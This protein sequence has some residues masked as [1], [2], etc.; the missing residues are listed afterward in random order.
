MARATSAC[1]KV[2]ARLGI[3]S[4]P[5]VNRKCHGRDDG[6]ECPQ[7]EQPKRAL[8]CAIVGLPGLLNAVVRREYG[9]RRARAVAPELAELRAEMRA[10][11]R[12]R[13]AVTVG[14]ALLLGGLVW[15]GVARG[16][17]WLGWVLLAAGVAKIAYGLW[18]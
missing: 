4:S 17:D 11:G 1:V 14:A 5:I 10:A 12:R 16:P 15:L 7:T 9:A 8:R 13:D 6:C 2:A 18:R 3:G